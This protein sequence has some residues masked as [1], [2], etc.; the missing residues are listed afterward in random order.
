[1]R[2][3]DEVTRDL[4]LN[5]I[6][7]AVWHV[8]P[9]PAGLTGF[10]LLAESHLACHTFPEHGS[11]CF[12]LFCSRPAAAWP[13]PERLGQLLGAREVDVARLP[14]NYGL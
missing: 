14:R 5:A 8:F 1:M 11:A 13:W 6:Q 9:G 2:V 3:F 4:G 7:P 12:N 10:V